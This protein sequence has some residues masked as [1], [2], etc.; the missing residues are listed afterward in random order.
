M[1]RRLDDGRKSSSGQRTRELRSQFRQTPLQRH[2]S[3]ARGDNRSIPS[4]RRWTQQTAQ[5]HQL[6]TDPFLLHQTM[7]RTNPAHTHGEKPT[8]TRREELHAGKRD[9]R[10]SSCVVRIVHPTSRRQLEH[11]YVLH[12]LGREEVGPT[13]HVQSCLLHNIQQSVRCVCVGRKEDRVRRSCGLRSTK[14]PYG[15]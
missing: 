13:E 1:N 2:Q 10:E 9:V 8:R 3:N 14:L 7:A 15:W 4:R 12:T 5:T 6:P 11:R